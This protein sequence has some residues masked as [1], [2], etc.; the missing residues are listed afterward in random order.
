[1]TYQAPD[2]SSNVQSMSY[3]GQVAPDMAVGTAGLTWQDLFSE[4]LPGLLRETGGSLS[5]FRNLGD[6]QIGH[7]QVLERQPTLTGLGDATMVEDVGRSGRKAIVAV[8]D[9]VAGF[10]RLR[11]ETGVDPFRS[12]ESQPTGGVLGDNLRLVELDG[13]G[14][15]D[16][17]QTDGD[18]LY[19][20]ASRGEQGFDKAQRLTFPMRGA[21]R[22]AF[23]FGDALGRVFLADMSGDGLTD[24]VRIENGQ[25]IYWPNLGRG[26]F[27]QPV[28]MD[29]APVFDHPD[30]F[31]LTRLR[32]AD[33]DG[34]GLAD[35]CYLSP[36]GV[37]VWR[38]RSGNGWSDRSDLPV[39]F[40]K[41]TPMSDVTF[42]EVTGNGTAS[43]AWVDNR[44]AGADGAIRFVELTGGKKPYLLARVENGMGGESKLTYAPSTHYY[45]QDK[46]AGRPWV[47]R[48]GY[49]VHCL[50]S[51]EVIDRVTGLHFT[52]SYSYHH[53]A[54]DPHDR[55][56]RGFA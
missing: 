4:G 35:L 54:Y 43:V 53:G 45:L 46:R 8:E 20:S 39:L 29:A 19:W 2:W 31:D 42:A 14:L 21:G 50:A 24:V 38:N 40:P 15:A 36:G 13:D 3:D 41:S 5:Y 47:S 49:P 27:G 16:L 22:A 10:S 34:S 9:G 28:Q 1:M 48:I 23:V 30:Q 51:Q 55:E 33:I 11:G 25:V 12:F 37:S 17:L 56:F 32:L 44:R 26:H 7:E 18:Y 6:G 52:S